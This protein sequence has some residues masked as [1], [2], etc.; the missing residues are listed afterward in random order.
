MSKFIVGIFALGCLAAPLFADDAA[1]KDAAAAP[2]ATEQKTDG[3]T[4]SAECK[5]CHK[6]MAECACKKG[7]KKAK[8]G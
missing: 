3:E 1:T 5:H 2:A 4:K 8:K 7:K 6:P